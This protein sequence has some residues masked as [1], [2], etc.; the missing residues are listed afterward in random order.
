M[1]KNSISFFASLNFVLGVMYAYS[2]GPLIESE[3]SIMSARDL[4][5]SGSDS[6]EIIVAAL[7]PFLAVVFAGVAAATGRV[8]PKKVA[9]IYVGCFV[10]AA[11]WLYAV[12]LDTGLLDSICLG[13]W[14]LGV[15]LASL[16]L[17]LVPAA[18]IA[19]GLSNNES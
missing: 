3:R 12:D 1:L 9:R 15:A 11:F 19:V 7:I 10:W 18:I 14:L 4:V 6:D 8:R 17:G 16:V 5:S 13:D 2:D